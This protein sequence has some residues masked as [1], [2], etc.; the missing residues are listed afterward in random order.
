MD[1]F[2]NNPEEALKYA[3]PLDDIGSTRGG[4]KSQLDLLK[5]WFDFSLLGNNSRSSSGSINLGDHYYELQKQYNAT[6]QELI[7]QKD[8]HK[9]AFIYMKLL[10]NN[11]MAAQTLE[12]GNHFQEAAT[13]YLKH[14]GN[15]NKAAECYEKGN[16]TNEAIEIYKELNENEKVGDLYLTIRKRKEADLYFEKVVT[17]YKS[18]NQYVKA[19]LIYKNK[20][21]NEQ[22]GQSLLLEGWRSFKDPSN[23]LNNYFSNIRDIKILK[24]EIETIYANDLN[25]Q[26][27][28]TFLQVIRHEY[29]KNNELSDSIREMAYEIVAAQ[30]PKNPSIVSE[31]K[32]FN[33]KDKELMKDTIRFKVNRKTK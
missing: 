22:G 2:K 25:R 6:A 10:K 20:M 7:K 24:R 18:K 26:N 19:S 8:Y 17:N 13:I 3:I 21:N 29:N 11:L 30:I 14:A 5:R 23:C 15:K 9:A 1:M 4:N 27:S 31:L 32:E 28:E 12:S 16:M 33:L